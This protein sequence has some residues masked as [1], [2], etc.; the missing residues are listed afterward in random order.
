MLRSSLGRLCS[1]AAIAGGVLAIPCG[2]LLAADGNWPQWRGPQAT[3]AVA[4]AS[5]PTTWGEGKNVK[6]KVALPG[7]GSS[8]PIVWD[9]KLFLLAAV[10]TGKAGQPVAGAGPA[11]QPAGEQPPPRPAPGPGG[12]GG[13]PG[14]RPGGRPGGFGGP[15]GGGGFGG[16]AAPT[17]AYQFAVLC[18]DR[19]TGKTLWQKNVAEVVP[20]EGHHRDNNFASYSPVTDGKVLIAFFGSRGLHCLDLD[21]NIKW[22]KELGK[23]QTRNSFGEGGSPALYGNTVV[24]QWDHEGQ[25][26]FIAA[27]DK[28]TGKELW[29]APR[30][31]ATGWSTPLIVEHEGKPQVITAN[32]SKVISYDLATGKQIWEV[33]PLTANVIPSPVYANGMLYVMSGF[34]GAECFAIKLGK[35]GNLTG[36]DAIVWQHRKG[37]PYVPSPLLYRDRLY[38]FSGNNAVLSAL[39]AKTGKPLIDSE[40]L[41]EMQNVYASPVGAGDYVYLTARNGVTQVIKATS[42]KLEV[43]ATNRLEE[44]IDASPAV[45]GK[46]M[47]LRGTKSLYCIGE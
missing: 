36:T 39:D 46:T 20:H 38:F 44:G 27:F 35:T 10:S 33:G 30:N 43:V 41:E 40:R 4:E 18:L 23:M 34:R 13:P 42:D 21:G 32:T 24:V 31:E 14:R 22:S 12:P 5:P 2:F 9:N 28:D 29:R 3:G 17:Q 37:T 6:W 26:D 47:Y 11:A 19:V 16:G 45:V 15:G 8:T 7:E 1:S 25:D